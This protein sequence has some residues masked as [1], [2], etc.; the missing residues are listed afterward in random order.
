MPVWDME[1]EAMEQQSITHQ[2]GKWEP[3]FSREPCSKKDSICK[4][5]QDLG[6]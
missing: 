6:R 5:A 3:R 1:V 4:E 2:T